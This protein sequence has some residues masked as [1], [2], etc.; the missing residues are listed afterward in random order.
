MSIIKL[1]NPAGQKSLISQNVDKGEGERPEQLSSNYCATRASSM[2][3]KIS[4]P[5]KMSDYLSDVS[6]S[7]GKTKATH[8]WVA[9]GNSVQQLRYS[10]KPRITN[11]QQSITNN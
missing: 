9:M 6:K 10:F 5:A 7:D 8:F 11:N 3:T 4:P 1:V 2:F